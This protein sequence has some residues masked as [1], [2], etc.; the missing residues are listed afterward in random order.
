ML[1]LKPFVKVAVSAPVLTVTV[2]CPPV[3]CGS[4]F[5]IAVALVGLVTVSAEARVIPGPKSAVV[6]P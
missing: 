2:R 4:M 6:V 5:K 1:T 3:A